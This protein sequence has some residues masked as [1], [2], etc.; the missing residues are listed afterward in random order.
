MSENFL[1]LTGDMLKYIPNYDVIHHLKIANAFRKINGLLNQAL[2]INKSQSS[3]YPNENFTSIENNDICSFQDAISTSTPQCRKTIDQLNTPSNEQPKLSI[4]SSKSDHKLFKKNIDLSNN[5]FTFKAAATKK[6]STSNDFFQNSFNDEIDNNQDD[7]LMPVKI[8]DNFNKKFDMTSK[9]KPISQVPPN[10]SNTSFD[11]DLDLDMIADDF[12]DL[13]NDNSMDKDFNE[14]CGDKRVE[15]T[16]FMNNN[17]FNGPSTSSS[18]HNNKSTT[19]TSFKSPAK[20]LF[21]G[22]IRNDGETGEFSAM[23]YPHTREMLKVFHQRFGLR[24]FRNNQKE[25]VNA[26][27]LGKDCFVIMPTGGGKSLCYQL[28]ACVNDGVTI[29]VSPLLS[30]IQDQVQ[31]LSSLDIPASHLSGEMSMNEENMIYSE[32]MKR[33][34]GLKLLYVTPEK[35]SSSQKFGSALEALYQRQKLCRFVIDEAHCVSQWGHDFRP[36]YKKMGFLRQR[37]P[38]VPIMA[39]TATATPRVRTDILNQLKIDHSKW[40]ISSFNRSNLRY[41]ILPKPG[42]KTLNSEIANLI[43]SKYKNKSGIIYCLSRKECDETAEEL[44][45]AKLSVASYHAGLCTRDRTSVQHQW[46]NEKFKI[47]CATI[48]FGMGIDKPDVRFVI[49]QS[50][51]KSIEGYYQESGRAGRD[52]ETADCILYYSYKDVNRIRSMIEKDRENFDAKKTHYNNLYRMVSY[53]LNRL[54]CRRS[55]LLNYFG[56]NFDRKDCI[57]NKATTCDNC[58]SIGNLIKLDVTQE[59]KLAIEA[60]R[61]LSSGSGWGNNITVNHLCEIF[62]GAKTKKL[63]DAG[64]NRHPAYG[65]CSS[66]SKNDLERL[67]Q[68]LIIENY[69]KEIMM[70]SGADFPVAYIR[71]G[72][73]A[74]GFLSSNNKVFFEIPKSNSSSNKKELVMSEPD[75]DPDIIKLQ[76]DCHAALLKTV[77]ALADARGVNYTSIVNTVALRMMAYKMPETEEE[78]RKIPH[79]TQANFDKYGAAL[80]DVTQMYAANKLVLLSERDD[81]NSELNGYSNETDD[82]YCSLNDIHAP[83]MSSPYFGQSSGRGRGG[84]GKRSFRGIKRKRKTTSTTQSKQS[85]V[86]AANGNSFQV[87]VPRQSTTAKKKTSTAIRSTVASSTTSF[88]PKPGLMSAPKP[89][90]FLPNPKCFTIPK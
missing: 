67:L 71:V 77:K 20:P 36:D 43:K 64:H 4:L 50:L 57:S 33:C 54:D 1:T 86:T 61:Q 88:T 65:A 30:L 28:P 62:K 27:L 6:P 24:T 15:V 83:D 48:A 7:S 55:Q 41:E 17:N 46:I 73:K 25:V 18:Q 23:N 5:K 34:P 51:P 63:I 74:A 69:L 79:I 42:K 85:K 76:E 68:R 44:S 72:D 81:Q 47:V 16:P 45:K 80:L 89:R 10:S 40:F 75:E 60:A 32:L 39:L 38:N 21:H 11:L 3:K 52:G 31:K 22:N 29:V 19:E 87:K 59:A 35:L 70:M 49:H 53:C 78:M 14:S 26:A 56:Q 8:G 66:W 37:F 82:D 58:N 9:Q 2:D 13:H 90:S 12:E 84:R